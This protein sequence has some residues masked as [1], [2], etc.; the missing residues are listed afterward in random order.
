MRSQNPKVSVVIPT[1]N[2][3]HLLPRAIQSVLDQTYQDLE[4]IIVDDGSRDNTERVIKNFKDE[5]IRYIQH[6]QNKG[7]SAARNTG[8]RESRGKYIAFQ[9][10][11]DEWF[12]NKLEKQI[13]AFADAPPEVGIVYSGFYR[14]EA[15]RKLYLPSDQLSLKEGNIHNELL[16]GNFVGTPTVL[17]KKECFRNQRYFNE[18]LPALEDW[19]LW[20]ELSK[21]YT[22]RYI[23]KPLLCSYSTPNSIN[24]NENNMLKAHEIILLTHLDDFSKNKKNLSEHYYDIGTG[25]CSI[26][27]FNNG[28]NYLI[29][30][31]KA[32]CL[33][34]KT[35]SV[36][37]ILLFGHNIYYKFRDLH[38][39]IGHRT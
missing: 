27:N 14:I 13:E 8:I 11:D 16:K 29:K 33:N 19:E 37:F 6:N 1:Y 7:A 31:L 36:L 21:Y 22:F 24:L 34:F 15:D 20:I 4:I 17:M 9:D 25:L 2:R 38:R 23:K 10:S 32:Y 35:I 18:S 26:G 5:R 28:K 39:K 12:S 3:A 30:S